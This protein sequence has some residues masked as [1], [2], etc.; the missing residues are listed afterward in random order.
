MIGILV[1][2]LLIMSLLA[3]GSMGLQETMMTQA[4]TMK[5]IENSNDL[6]TIK[7]ALILSG[8]V[9]LIYGAVLPLGI[10]TGSYHKIPS[11][12][13]LRTKNT[14]NKDYIYCPFA[15]NQTTLTQNIQLTD[16]AVYLADTAMINHKGT[17]REYVVSSHSSPFQ[18]LGVRAMII[19]PT[20]PFSD[21]M[22]SCL[23]VAYNAELQKFIVDGGRV[24]VITATDIEIGN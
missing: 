4:T 21:T 16:L 14:F 18:A 15:E 8:K 19:S 17:D 6:L 10:N 13:Y 12:V 22:P 23:D 2:L 11:F 9:D 1:M 3:I 5:A 24:E 7:K 20:P